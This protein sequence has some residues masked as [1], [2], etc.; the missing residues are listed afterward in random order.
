[1][2][3]AEIKNLAV[4]EYGNRYQVSPDQLLRY[5]NIVQAMAFD[6]DLEAFKDFSNTLT[7]NAGKGPYA[8]PS[9]PLVRKLIGITKAT[10][11]Q[12]YAV[13]STSTGDDYGFDGGFNPERIWE[14]IR[15]SNF[16]TARQFSFIDTPS[17]TAVYR[18][19]YYIRPP[20]ITSWTD[21]TKLRIPPEYHWQT[22][23][24]SII[25][26]A[27][28]ATYGDKQPLDAVLPYLEPFWD[29][30]RTQYT[31]MGGSYDMGISSGSLP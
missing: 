13:P 16:G 1:M 17:T 4:A 12:L 27:D 8:F 20:V 26:L 3:L 15:V 28:N 21:D 24:Q 18:W 31:P 7:V 2:T 29:A 22:F 25:A 11:A 19:V 10:D 6:K 23:Y 5:A 30:V 9:S 14:K